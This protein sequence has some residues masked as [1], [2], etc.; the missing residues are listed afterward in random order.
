MKTTILLLLLTIVNT[1]G[2]TPG[3]ALDKLVSDVKNLQ[4]EIVNLKA[5]E[6]G[7]K[8]EV[9]SL[10]SEL[11]SIQKK[12][13]NL[14]TEVATLKT[15]VARKGVVIKNLQKDVG[16]FNAMFSCSGDQCTASSQYFEFPKGIIVGTRKSTCKYGDGILSV[17]YGGMNCPSGNGA[18]TFGSANTASGYKSVVSGYAN[19]ASGDRSVVTG[20][21]GNAASGYMSLVAGGKGNT[22]STEYSSKFGG[23][24]N[25]L[26]R[27]HSYVRA[28]KLGA[29]NGELVD[30]ENREREDTA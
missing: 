26:S 17:D 29:P 1:K 25:Q 3:R 4:R 30:D 13:T 21:S 19:T 16:N 27:T 22:A 2:Q 9:A 14:A 10:K 6:V 7:L 23:F 24:N 15:K 12:E 20:G 8:G 18:V 28:E 5:G 11:A